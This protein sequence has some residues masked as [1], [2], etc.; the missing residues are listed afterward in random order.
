MCFSLV[1]A[2]E[3]IARLEEEFQMEQWGLVE[4]GHDL[5]RAACKVSQSFLSLALPGAA[6]SGLDSWNSV[7]TGANMEHDSILLRLGQVQ[8]ASTASFLYLLDGAEG[9][10][11]R[12]AELRA[13]LDSLA[14]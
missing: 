1:I 3:E 6:L 12:V 9:H 14:A 5:D 8:F 4:G 2:A 13:A 11:K 10:I 7:V